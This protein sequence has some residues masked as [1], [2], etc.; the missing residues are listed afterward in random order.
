[1]T[2]IACS[3]LK[4]R[5][6]VNIIHYIK[7]LYSFFYRSFAV[8]SGYTLPRVGQEGGQSDHSLELVCK[9]FVADDLRKY[10]CIWRF[11]AFVVSAG[12]LESTL[13]L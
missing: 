7:L 12:V 10:L 9:C 4:S 11:L 1:M 13:L 2:D 6:T 3:D 8:T 5:A